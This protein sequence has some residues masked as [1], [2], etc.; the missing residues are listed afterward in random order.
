[1]PN[2]LE[3]YPIV[4]EIPVAW[5]EMDALNHVNNVV[6]FRYFETARLD[7]FAGI[8][9][10]EEMQATQTGPVLSETSSR[11]RRPV[12]YPDKLLVGS[13]ISELT[14]D[15]FVMEYKIVSQ[16]QGAVTTS[17]TAKVVMFNFKQQKRASLSPSLVEKIVSMQPE[18]A[19]FAVTTD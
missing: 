12:T 10:M 17:G 15:S 19:E 14:G 5:G 1:M 3:G 11:Y 16:Q 6:Y 9:L 13:R 7:Y 18:L 8:G 2:L 4:T